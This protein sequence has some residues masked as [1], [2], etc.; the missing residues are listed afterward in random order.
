VFG[1]GDKPYLGIDIGSAAVKV[2]LLKKSKKGFDLLNFGMVSLPPDTIVDGA[3][4]NPEAVVDAIKK[5]IL[6]EKLS[7]YRECV[8]TV[9]GQSVIIKKIT[10]P[11]M[12][13][14]DLAQSI[15]QE[16]EQYI[17]FDIEEVNVDFQ[18]VKAE[19][20]LPKKGE[21]AAEGD[22]RQMDVLLVAAKKDMIKDSIALLQQAGLKPVLAD[23]DVFA[24]ENSFELAM[25][26]DVD[27]TFALLNIGA[28]TTNL[29]IIEG[30][31]TAF[32]RD[33][34]AGGASITEA[35]QKGLNVP[36]R[37]AESIKMGHLPDNIKKQDVVGH[38]RTGMAALCKEISATL[39]NFHKSSDG[40]VRRLYLSGG[41]A[42]MEGVES[43]ITKEIGLECKKINPFKNLKVNTKN[44]DPEYLD[45]IGPMATIAIGLATR[46]LD[47]K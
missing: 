34:P 10:V 41:V 1:F 22:D 14:E 35:I 13:E 17:P 21:K 27:D 4:E 7:G 44:F 46:A 15:Q 29:N 28:N 26:L 19:G 43:L 6:A 2:A 47:D 38:I 18:V 11:L 32:T 5:L 16:A 37:D 39:D 42:M 12:S 8:F 9:S 25:G 31:I 30:G 36:N 23:L 45:T 20:E 33:I 40:R 24:L 3:V